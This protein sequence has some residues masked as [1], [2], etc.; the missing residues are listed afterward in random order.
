M[1]R[2]P[3]S[4][5]SVLKT[6]ETFELF[7]LDPERDGGDESSHRIED[8]HVLGATCID[9]LDTREAVVSQLA[10]GA[11][12]ARGMAMCFIPR[13]AVRAISLVGTV[14]LVICFQCSSV[15]YFLDGEFTGELPISEKPHQLLDQILLHANIPLPRPAHETRPGDAA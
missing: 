2:F 3:E 12:Q 14:E 15:H 9:D 1:N 8:W 13:H 4:V 10:E 7:S 6:A 5:L 11:A